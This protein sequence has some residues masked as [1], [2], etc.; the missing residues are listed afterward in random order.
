MVQPENGKMYVTHFTGNGIPGGVYPS[1]VAGGTSV[2]TG[3][4]QRGHEYLGENLPGIG[5]ANGMRQTG[6]I[7][8]DYPGPALVDRII[9]Y[10]FEL[11]RPD[12]GSP[13]LPTLKAP[14]Q[15]DGNSELCLAGGPGGD[16]ATNSRPALMT[17]D[18]SMQQ[19]WSFMTDSTIT[20]GAKC[21]DAFDGG[22]SPGTPVQL[23]DC[24]G[25]VNQQWN[26]TNE[27]TIVNAQSMTCLSPV[28]FGRVENTEMELQPCQEGEPN[29]RWK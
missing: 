6:M 2:Y 7:M 5:G 4:N 17:C 25:G 28:G 24:H 10:N 13:R 27:G 23:Y 22:T 12:P 16:F 8:M 21:L 29:Q 11:G 19:E 1:T 3:V 14:L 20:I 15:S 26:L 9:S 18:G